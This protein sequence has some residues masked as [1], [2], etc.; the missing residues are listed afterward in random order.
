MR[1][2]DRERATAYVR[3]HRF[4]VGAPAHFDERYDAVSA[5][6]YVLAAIGG[7]LVN[8]FRRVARRRRLPID[9]VEAVVAGRLANPLAYLGVVGETGSPG[10]GRVSVRVY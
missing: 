3:Q 9:D 1:A 7:D 5:V 4:A 8:G 10:L 2:T 6:E